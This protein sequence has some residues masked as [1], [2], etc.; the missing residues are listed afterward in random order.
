[1]SADFVSG[2]LAWNSSVVS[3]QEIR[4]VKGKGPKDPEKKKKSDKTVIDVSGLKKMPDSKVSDLDDLVASMQAKDIAP[5]EGSGYKAKPK[6]RKPKES[7]A[8]IDR[9][10]AKYHIDVA[11]KPKRRVKRT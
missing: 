1:M 7:E 6:G 9:I 11:T 5:P 8:I 4:V 10:A 3:D 2:R